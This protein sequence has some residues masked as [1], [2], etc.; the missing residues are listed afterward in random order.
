MV[1]AAAGCS[2][3]GSFIT[4]AVATG[5]QVFGS[6]LQYVRLAC[7]DGELRLD[8]VGIV[9]PHEHATVVAAALLALKSERAGAGSR[10]GH[11]TSI[12]KG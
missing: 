2:D 3:I 10:A 12:V 4:T 7:C 1:T 11:R 8:F 5:A 9:Q 6:A